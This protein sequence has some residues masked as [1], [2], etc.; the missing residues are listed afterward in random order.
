MLAAMVPGAE[1]GKVMRR[2]RFDRPVAEIGRG[3]EQGAVD[4][5]QRDIDRQDCIGRPGMGEGDGDGGWVVEQEFQ[6][7]MRPDRC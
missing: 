5:L 1:S 3:L 6:R 2:K 4:L 7:L